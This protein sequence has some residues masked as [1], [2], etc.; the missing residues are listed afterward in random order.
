MRFAG[1]AAAAQRLRQ[2]HDMRYTSDE[3]RLSFVIRVSSKIGSTAGP[4]ERSSAGQATCIAGCFWSSC[5]DIVLKGH[6]ITES[7][8]GMLG[9]GLSSPY[10]SRHVAAFPLLQ[11]FV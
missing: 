8:A 1:A 2:S 10:Y 5:Q 3:L 11:A 9:V 4:T 6:D 7:A